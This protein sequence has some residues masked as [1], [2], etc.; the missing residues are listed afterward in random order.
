MTFTSKST[1]RTVSRSIAGVV[2]TCLALSAC[3]R[4]G[5]SKQ[6][7]LENG[8]RFLKDGKIQEAIVEFRNAIKEDE[9]YG[10]AR[11]QLAEAYASKGEGAAAAREYV[12]A[13][14]LLPAENRAQIKA[15][16][17]LLLGK[18]FEDA[19]TRAQRVVDRDPSNA[20]AQVLLGKALAGLNDF[21]G[22][23]KQLEEAIEI[24]PNRAQLY[25]S[26][27]ILKQ[28][29][30]ESAMA[31][32]AFEKAVEVEP[33]SL[34][35][36]LDLASFRWSNGD[37]RGAEDGLKTAIGIDAKSVLANRALATLY[38]SSGRAPLAEPYVK[39]MVEAVDTPAAR[40]QLADYYVAIKRRNE[41]VAILT[42]LA[43][44]KGGSGA[45]VRLAAI[46]Y[47]TGNRS[48]GHS[49]LDALLVNEP[50]NVQALL[51]KAQWLAAEGKV[52]EAAER[53]ST[54]AKA[55]PKSAPAV[56]ALGTLQVRLHRSADA[57]A[58]F[59]QALVLNPKLTQAAVFLSELNLRA[60]SADTALEY[61]QNAAVASPDDPVVKAT[62]VRNL[63]ATGDV[64]S[65]QKEL[66]ILLK[67]HPRVA[68]VQALDGALRLEK[69]DVA[70]ARAS[71][72]RAL[73]L[74]PDNLE[75]LSAVTLLDL[76]QKRVV[77]A[78]T[79]LQSSLARDANRPELLT[80]LA[81]IEAANRD[82]ASA[83][84]SLRRAIEVAPDSPSP[85]NM[86]A[87]V[88]LRTGR[89]EAGLVELDRI[90]AREPKNIG[91]RTMAAMVVD[92]QRKLT[93]AKK[94]YQQILEID[95]TAAVAANNLAW[96]W[97]NEGEQ[98]DEA[99]RLA[100]SALVRF[101]DSP[102]I[103]DTI[104]W[105]YY[106]KE[107]PAL[108]VTA[109]RASIEKEPSN[110]AYRFHLAQALAKTGDRAEARRSAELALKMKPDYA[111]ARSFLAT[112][113]G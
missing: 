15:A 113:A 98:L 110:P 10:E 8:N 101:P 83:E 104:G 39:A 109:L 1:V 91:V 64:P 12:R 17:F 20:E 14:D 37:L 3:S 97:A 21:E 72:E 94:R 27:A 75:A 18:Q 2:V 31:K 79:R 86:L 61:A 84:K 16:T 59:T 55:D 80:L 49:K 40:L 45:V 62:L 67:N 13:A 7:F 81:R 33:R 53:A 77:Q 30:G 29:Q 88:Y 107:L 106:R 66:T 26:L 93:E 25:S 42:P 111:E 4:G 56:Y 87:G 69:N 50:H 95:P 24:S 51:L 63:I 78:R 38:T 28:K 57:M 6:T 105:I 82:F 46:A 23:L 9:R 100:Q 90:A 19:K 47:Q 99:L 70:G 41:A 74:N 5:Q 73:A 76:G 103:Q 108:A 89:S 60:G 71:F 11:F 102:Q 58:S 54:A 48:G 96:I 35:A 43:A 52:E 32:A 85:Y 34:Q 36:W 22:A 65:A 44:G 112:L 92:S 68:A